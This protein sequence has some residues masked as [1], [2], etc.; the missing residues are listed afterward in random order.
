MP[1]ISV[2]TYS[3]VASLVSSEN[4]EPNLGGIFFAKSR[5]LRIKAAEISIFF[6][7]FRYTAILSLFS[8]LYNIFI[9]IGDFEIR[10]FPIKNILF[11]IY[12]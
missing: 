7:F 2:A 11:K 5:R 10:I 6:F 12:V 1:Y 9:H 4:I 8:P 3:R